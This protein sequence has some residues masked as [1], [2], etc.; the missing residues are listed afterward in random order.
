MGTFTIVEIA[1][2][3][4]PNRSFAKS[5]HLQK[6]F[7]KC[8]Q[9]LS[10]MTNTRSETEDVAACQNFETVTSASELLIRELHTVSGESA[11]SK[12]TSD[13]L[14]ESLSESLLESLLEPLLESPLTRTVTSNATISSTNSS[15]FMTSRLSSD[16]QSVPIVCRCLF[17]VQVSLSSRIERY[18]LSNAILYAQ[19][20]IDATSE[21]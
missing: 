3:G 21:I 9:F 5:R 18:G 14:L 1:Y 2:A 8:F 12:D 11:L 6:L 19:T 4:E 7:V 17:S 10:Q 15:S 13:R 20:A 16:F